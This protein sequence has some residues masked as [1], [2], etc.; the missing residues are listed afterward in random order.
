MKFEQR[1]GL[2][3]GLITAPVARW[4]SLGW[5]GAILSAAT[6]ANAA[7]T[8]GYE[9]VIPRAL[10]FP[11]DFGAHLGF[12]TEWWY[13]TGWLTTASGKTLGVQVT[14]F[15]AR[16]GQDDGPDARIEAIQSRFSARQLL[17]AHAAIADPEAKVLWHDERAARAGT[18]AADFSEEDTR[19]RIGAW[20][21]DR[22]GP[23]DASRYRARI[24][25]ARFEYDLQFVAPSEPWLQG[26]AGYSRKGP[27]ASQSSHYYTQAPLQVRGSV[28]W[29]GG[30]E[31][32]TG[33]AWMDHEWSST[34]L[35]PEASGWDW[36][37]MNLDDG[38]SLKAFQVRHRNGSAIWTEANLRLPNGQS[39]ALEGVQFEPLRFWTS[40]A[41]GARW[42]VA[43][44]LTLGGERYRI[45]PLFDAQELDSRGSVGS[46]YW[47]GAS[48]L[49]D[50]SGQTIGRGYLEMTGYHEAIRL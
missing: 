5:S 24:R 38:R 32:V 30:R 16:P 36:I 1:R 31:Q 3:K 27:E 28:L 6:G 29:P 12:R 43:Q 47:E 18:G 34:L 13:L 9:P 4:G 44:A 33:M 42:P 8:I 21:L 39:Q 50:A 14:F 48:A 45:E 23:I 19:V 22:V 37:G 15:R 20:Q 10:V 46:V 7:Q 40:P 11:R 17:F 2:L 25:S 35:H 41:T 26:D 49:L